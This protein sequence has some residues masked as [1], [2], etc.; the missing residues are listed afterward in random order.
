MRERRDRP[1]HD[2]SALEEE[3]FIVK[4]V[5]TPSRDALQKDA[6][7]QQLIESAKSL[8]LTVESQRLA[9][10]DSGNPISLYLHEIERYKLLTAEQEILLAQR[11][12]GGRIAYDRLTGGEILSAEEKRMLEK[13]KEDGDS[14]RD[15]L[16]MA[17]TRLVISVAKKYK[18][19]SPFLD[20]IQDGNM[21]LMTAVEKFDPTMGIRF[22]TYATWWIRQSITRGIN[23][24]SRT[25]RM[26]T[27]M[28][29]RLNDFRAK[30][31]ALEENLGREPKDKEIARNLNI[32]LLK[33]KEMKAYILLAEGTR[34][35]NENIGAPGR[36]DGTELGDI[37]PDS[38]KSPETMALQAPIAE[39]L[40]NIIYDGETLNDKE[41]AVLELRFGLTATPLQQGDTY[42]LEEIGKEWGVTRERVRQMQESALRKL[43]HKTKNKRVWN[44]RDIWALFNEE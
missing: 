41:I 17:N 39:K 8:D 42:T 15:H 4:E 34:S 23:E 11:Y 37:I 26:G 40:R 38:A 10:A 21:G 24:G 5:A 18:G 20:L 2:P 44:E 22:S 35:L 30:K 3:G 12:Q 9:A 31:A 29:E 19:P 27:H 7:L 33:V 13:E 6:E 36:E 43:R 14:A 1:S 28:Y 25:I 16:T 32:S